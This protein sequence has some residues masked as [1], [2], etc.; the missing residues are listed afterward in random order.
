M[1]ISLTCV[2][3][4][5]VFFTWS[6]LF[7]FRSRDT[8]HQQQDF[9]SISDNE[10]FDQGADNPPFDAISDDNE[11]GNDGQY[12]RIS[13][14]DNA[15][16]ATV[17]D[18]DMATP[19]QSEEDEQNEDYVHEDEQNVDMIDDFD[20]KERGALILMMKLPWNFLY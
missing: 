19:E 2:A 12:E 6:L 20:A 1:L 17:S 18:R 16:N 7:T 9:D 13:E 14:D 3:K 5:R 10:A 4:T 11:E 8:Q 15:S